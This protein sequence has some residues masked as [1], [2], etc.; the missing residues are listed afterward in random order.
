MRDF[1]KKLIA[2]NKMLQA[3]IKAVMICNVGYLLFYIL[4]FGEI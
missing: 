4:V 1:R 3:I 2:I